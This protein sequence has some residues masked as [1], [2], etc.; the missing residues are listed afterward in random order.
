MLSDFQK[1]NE[2]FDITIHPG[3]FVLFLLPNN[4]TWNTLTPEINKII[5]NIDDIINFYPD[6]FEDI[7]NLTI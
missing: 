2:Q 3:K 6:F 4:I 5:P 7:I 1:Y